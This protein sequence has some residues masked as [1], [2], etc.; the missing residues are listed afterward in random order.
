MIGKEP[1]HLLDSL[2]DEVLD[3]LSISFLRKETRVQR[4]SSKDVKTSAAVNTFQREKEE[5][6]RFPASFWLKTDLEQQKHKKT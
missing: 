5:K 2:V 6:S 3:S 1:L 4:L